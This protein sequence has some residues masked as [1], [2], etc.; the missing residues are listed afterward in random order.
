[1]GSISWDNSSYLLYLKYMSEGEKLRECEGKVLELAIPIGSNAKTST[2]RSHVVP[3]R[4]YLKSVGLKNALGSA[5]QTCKIQVPINP[6]GSSLI[7]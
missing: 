2:L 1:M 5:N 6:A 4:Q 3:K 7:T